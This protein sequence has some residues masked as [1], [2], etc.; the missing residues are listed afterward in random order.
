MLAACSSSPP[1]RFYTLN[2][3]APVAAPVAAA[4]SGAIPVRVEPVVIPAEL[5]RPE[6]VIHSDPN[7]VRF[8][9]LDR[10]AAPLDE[11]IRRVLSDDLA[12]R[13]PSN[14]VADPNEPNTHEPRRTL[15][16][17]ISVFDADESCAVTLN[18][19]WTLHTPDAGNRSGLEHIAQPSVGT[20]PA[21]LPAAMS[22][23][24]ATF[25][26]RLAGILVR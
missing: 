12:A 18:A 5:D 7:R 9:D 16:V 14:A 3:I 2:Q 17:S 19:S 21:S 23:A 13:L 20:C 8:A 10:W 26:D 15:S 1:A 22:H 11:Q 25:A 6:M 4:G 24:L